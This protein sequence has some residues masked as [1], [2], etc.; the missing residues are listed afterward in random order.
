MSDLSPELQKLVL[1]GRGA[2]R[3][4]SAD[5]ERV[6]G[7]LQARLGDAVVVGGNLAPTL[8][9]STATGALSGK[10][11]SVAL[12]GMALIIGSIAWLSSRSSELDPS[13]VSLEASDDAVAST[14]IAAVAPA[15]APTTETVTPVLAEV[16]PPQT[17]PKTKEPNARVRESSRGRDSLAE[18]VSILSRA[19]TELHSGR[20]ENALKSLAEHE[21]RFPN[22]I[23]AE[24]RTAARIQALCA[25]GRSAQA[26]GQMARLRPGSL[27]GEQSQQACATAI[28]KSAN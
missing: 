8:A 21:R 9:V 1:A 7:T 11:L 20:A 23:L 15:I 5:F 17:Q 13:P 2:S 25:L 10:I 27:H 22:G 19:E 16:T 6:L 14:G 24:E 4:T 12:A 3:P 26:N 28:G 18:E